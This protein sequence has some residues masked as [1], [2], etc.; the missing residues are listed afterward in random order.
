MS[1]E[2]VPSDLRLPHICSASTPCHPHIVPPVSRFFETTPQDLISDGLYET[3]ALASFP[4]TFW[5]VSVAL[6]ARALG[7]TSATASYRGAFTPGAASQSIET[8]EERE[9][10]PSSEVSE[11]PSGPSDPE[12]GRPLKVLKR[13]QS[14]MF[15]WGADE[16]HSIARPPRWSERGRDS[17]EEEGGES[18]D[19]TVSRRGKGKR[20]ATTAEQI[21]SSTDV[22]A[23]E[24][25]GHGK[26]GG[27]S[28]AHAD[29]VETGRNQS[30]DPHELPG[31]RE[32]QRMGQ[33]ANEHGSSTSE[34]QVS[35][36]LDC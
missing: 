27:S 14:A 15:G 30:L 31:P 18:Q 9:S 22:A 1:W 10:G 13:E 20:P 2:A 29:R 12:M 33:P 23:K 21:T 3:L 11:R 26:D 25:R 5:P 19:R 7:A 4:G 8:N 36:T 34:D 16:E 35:V 28:V 6:V 17:W 24:Q 32:R